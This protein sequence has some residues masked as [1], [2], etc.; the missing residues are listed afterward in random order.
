MTE[1]LLPPGT[2]AAIMPISSAA[3][4]SGR[5]AG[6]TEFAELVRRAFRV[7]AAEGW[8]NITVSDPDFAD[9][10]LGEREVMQSLNDWARAGRSFVMLAGRYDEV[11]RRHA[12]FVTWRRMWAHVIDCRAAP[13]RA[14]ELPSALWSPAWVFERLEV[15]RCTGL[16]GAEP[17]RR[18]ELRERLA[19]PLR[20][21]TPSFAA[22]TLGL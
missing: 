11:L 3:L 14:A 21:S 17:V 8:S 20:R 2:P 16:A 4:L 10:P 15:E 7:A 19:E 6:R 22:H 5:F 1:P 9:W 13:P 18:V 12:R